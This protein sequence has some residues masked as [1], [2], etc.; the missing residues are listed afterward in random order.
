MDYGAILQRAWEIVWNNKFLILL[1]VLVAFSTGGGSSGNFGGGS[2]GGDGGEPPFDGTEPG[3]EEDFGDLTEE[4]IERMV[5]E[6]LAQYGLEMGL[7]LGVIV[8][9]VCVA[10]TIGLALWVVGTIATGGLIAAV[11]EIERGGKPTFGTAWQAGWQKGWRLIGIGLIP[12]LIGLLFLVVLVATAISFGVTADSFAS[13]GVEAMAGSL[14]V[15]LVCIGCLW[16]ITAI[17]IGLLRLLANRACMLE[18]AGVLEAYGRAWDVLR[19]HIGPIIIL[20]LIQL[21]I[22]IGVGFVLFLP[23]FV[24]A[25]CCILWP[26][27][28]LISG[29][30]EAYFST[31]WTLAWRSLVGGGDRPLI[32]AVEPKLG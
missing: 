21:G 22:S 32:Q 15:A 28:W 10:F 24:I 27:A 1:G 14:I 3:I 26:V 17:F 29:T 25:F 8:A 31:V 23:S 12:A 13:E 30:I 2:G 16:V 4:D 7:A 11:D 9:V 18:N 5:N 20:G 6:F 19:G